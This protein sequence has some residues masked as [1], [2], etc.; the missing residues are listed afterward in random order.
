MAD[1]LQIAFFSISIFMLVVIG[2]AKLLD[3]HEQTDLA[4]DGRRYRLAARS[5]SYE[6][7]DE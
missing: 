1:V 2:L 7:V 6:P 3:R 4:L 5:R